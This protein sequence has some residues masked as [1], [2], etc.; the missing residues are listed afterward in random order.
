MSALG[1]EAIDCQVLE[2]GLPLMLGRGGRII[3][4]APLHCDV[5]ILQRPMEWTIPLAIPMI[6][7]QGIKVIIELDDD[8]HTA[9]PHNSAFQLNHPKVNP[10]HNFHHLSE[11]VKLADWVTV[12]TPALAKRYGGHGRVSVIRNSVDDWLLEIPR[13]ITQRPAIGWPGTVTN[14]P[15]DLQATSG[16]VAMALRAHPEWQFVNIGGGK[17]QDEV[18]AGLGIDGPEFDDRFMAT[19]WKPL[20]LH[21]MLVSRLDLVIAPLELTVFNAGKSYLKGIEAMA[22]GIP[23]VASPTPEY[24]L[25]ASDNLPGRDILADPRWKD[26]RR[27]LGRLMDGTVDLAELGEGHREVAREHFAISQNAYRWAEVWQAVANR[28]TTKTGGL[29]CQTLSLR[30]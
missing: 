11:C 29:P 8:Y 24:Q 19:E 12:S 23:F 3:G 16:G 17:R 27:L 1:G 18:R 6:Q 26:W 30:R 28:Q 7:A 2:S 13:P 4:V 20:D 22:L 21:L 9:H 15:A 5:L 14:H 10:T 25:L